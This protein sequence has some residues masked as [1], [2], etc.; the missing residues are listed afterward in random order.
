MVLVRGGLTLR[1]DLTSGLVGVAVRAGL[2][3]FASWIFPRET[4]GR[5]G[6]QQCMI[7][8]IGIPLAN[9]NIILTQNKICAV[10]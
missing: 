4:A 6:R 5:L 2:S 1:N 9:F 7:V 3:R 10:K 8:W